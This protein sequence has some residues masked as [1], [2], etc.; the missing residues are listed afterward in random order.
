M[1]VFKM[2]DTVIVSIIGLVGTIGTAIISNWDKLF[3]NRT[4][5]DAP[6]KSLRKNGIRYKA[7]LI[8]AILS[9]GIIGMV[10]NFQKPKVTLTSDVRDIAG[11]QVELNKA[12]FQ[13]RVRGD[14]KNAQN[15]FVYLVVDDSHVLWIE[16]LQGLGPKTKGDFVALCYLGI[17]S[18]TMSINKPYRIFAV[19]TN[20]PYSDYDHLDKETVIAQS[21]AIELVRTR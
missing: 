9:I 4:R 3:Q 13:V 6:P 1:E 7:T 11:L 17:Q 19:V 12:P 16:P 10:F 21:N 5:K 20:K 14:A 18:D 2:S 15:H 8:F